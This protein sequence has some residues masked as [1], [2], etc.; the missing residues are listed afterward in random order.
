MFYYFNDVIITLPH[1]NVLLFDFGLLDIAPFLVVLFDVAL[2][3]VY[4]LVL[5]SVNAALRYVVFF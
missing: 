1:I 2:F 5:H 4:C 3:T